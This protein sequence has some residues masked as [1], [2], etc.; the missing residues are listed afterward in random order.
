[1]QK[2]LP[3]DDEMRLRGEVSER[4][5]DLLLDVFADDLDVVLQLSR[6]RNHGSALGDGALD[7]MQNLTEKKKLVVL[8]IYKF[9]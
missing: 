6:D 5:R 9:S 7:E 4:D 1:M 2:L 3:N 8:L